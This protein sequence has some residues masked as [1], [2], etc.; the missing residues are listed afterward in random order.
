[1][2]LYSYFRSSASYRVRIAL[3]LKQLP[4]DYVPVHLL[5][6]GGQ[7]LKD[8][9]RALSPDSLVP[10][11]VDGDAALQ[12]SLAIVEYLDE[13]HPEPPLLPKAPLDRAY[14]RSIALQIACEI[15]PLNNLRVLKYLKHMLQVPE[16]A[17]NDWYRH[18]IEAGFATL[19]A[20]LA[21]DPRTG[22]LCFGDT[23]TLADICVVPQVFN[24]NRF[25]IDTSRFPTIQRIYDHAM[26]LDA[27]KAAA[28]GAQPD[29]E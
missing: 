22:K 6:D 10:T 9:Y 7:Q 2:K 17:K 25:A 23:P 19:E 14:V 3:H 8:E 4:F 21:N 27:F 16:E 24:A 28:P 13:T 29:A 12:Q 18:W 20:R 11:L 15:H 1:M 5:R 26:T